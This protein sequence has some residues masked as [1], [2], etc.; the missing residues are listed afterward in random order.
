MRSPSP[1]PSRFLSLLYLIVLLSLFFSLLLSRSHIRSILYLSP[2]L[3]FHRSHRSDI[4]A[5]LRRR[6]QA[7]RAPLARAKPGRVKIKS[8]LICHERAPRLPFYPPRTLRRISAPR[9]G[10]TVR[11]T[12]RRLYLLPSVSINATRRVSVARAVYMAVSPLLYC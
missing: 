8:E 2:S 7:H 12:R 5:N 9:R 1:L 10:S 4:K 6:S 11:L 3:F